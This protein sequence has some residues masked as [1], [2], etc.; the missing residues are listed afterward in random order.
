MTTMEELDRRVSALE[1][2][3]KHTAETREWMAATL[4]QIAAVQDR[5]GKILDQPTVAIASLRAD[6]GVLKA[7]AGELKA[8]VRKVDKKIDDLAANLPAVLAEA[9]REGLQRK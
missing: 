3:Q 9:V 8:S 6:V 1:A 5:H 2:A 4:G 7:D